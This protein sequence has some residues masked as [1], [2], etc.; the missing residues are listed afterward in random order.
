MGEG[1]LVGDYGNQLMKLHFKPDLERRGLGKLITMSNHMALIC[2]DVGLSAAFYSDVMGFQQIDRP[3]FDTYG[4][5]FT[6]GNMEL[7]LIKGEPCVAYGED[8]IV[9]HLAVESEDIPAVMKKLREMDPPVEFQVN[10]SVP[11]GDETKIVQ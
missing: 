8:L 6:A 3:N 7:H 11:T 9:P 1:E 5:W 4:A 2:R 10:V